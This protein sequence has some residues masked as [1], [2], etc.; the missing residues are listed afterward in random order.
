MHVLY[1]LHTNSMWTAYCTQTNLGLQCKIDNNYINFHKIRL[2][3]PS[4]MT[5]SDRTRSMHHLRTGEFHTICT[6]I[7]LHSF[8][9]Q[10]TEYYQLLET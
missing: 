8:R 1:R 5:D 3:S 2:I 7:V 6:Y 10:L 9:V 4:E